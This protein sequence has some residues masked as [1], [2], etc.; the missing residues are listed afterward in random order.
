MKNGV[1]YDETMQDLW[2]GSNKDA[3]T[4]QKYNA[5]LLE[6][7]NN[8]FLRDNDTRDFIKFVMGLHYSTRKKAPQ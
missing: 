2:A 4:T 3:S 5:L 8:Q 6:R 7:A 1:K